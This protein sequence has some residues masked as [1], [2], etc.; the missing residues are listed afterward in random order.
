MHMEGFFEKEI[1]KELY[2][3]ED[4]SVCNTNIAKKK[5]LWKPLLFHLFK[6]DAI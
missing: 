4:A 5:N 6:T 3:I 2:Q 1:A